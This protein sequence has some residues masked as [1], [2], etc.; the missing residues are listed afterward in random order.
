MPHKH[1]TDRRHPIPKMAFKVENWPECEAGSRQCGSLTLWVEDGALDHWETLG[2]SGRAR[3][4]GAA[5]PEHADG[6]HGVQA[7][8]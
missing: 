7:G 3:C 2:P 1:N 8:V 6:S 5:T 4:T